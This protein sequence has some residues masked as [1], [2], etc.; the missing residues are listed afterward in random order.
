MRTRQAARLPSADHTQLETPLPTLVT[1]RGVPP[2]DAT[3]QSCPRALVAAR[4]AVVSPA[5]CA[6]MKPTVDPSGAH[7]GE[8]GAQLSSINTWRGAAAVRRRDPDRR[9]TPVLRTV[10]ARHHVH[11]LRAVGRHVRVGRELEAEIVFRRDAALGRGRLGEQ[12]LSG[13]GDESERWQ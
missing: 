8:L 12:R 5:A 11:D 10:D 2:V 6:E 4:R 3:V 7:R 9:H 13:N 1:R